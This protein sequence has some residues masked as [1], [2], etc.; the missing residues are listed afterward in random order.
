MSFIKPLHQNKPNRFPSNKTSTLKPDYKFLPDSLN[1]TDPK[2]CGS[3]HRLKNPPRPSRR[4]SNGL[5]S[6]KTKLHSSENV[7]RSM[8]SFLNN[9]HA[10]VRNK[11]QRTKFLPLKDCRLAMNYRPN[12]KLVLEKNKAESWL[13]SSLLLDGLKIS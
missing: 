8:T 6:G 7:T 2:T 9:C 4:H 10:V 11:E 3:L 13:Y 12:G 1:I 5:K